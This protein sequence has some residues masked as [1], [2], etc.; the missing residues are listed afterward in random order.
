MKQPG[1]NLIEECRDAKHIVVTGHI[2]PD[3][4][5]IGSTVATTLFLR[6][7]LPEA[8]VRL[9]LEK[10]MPSFDGVEGIDIIDSTYSGNENET[11]IC[12]VLDTNAG[13]IGS[14]DRFFEK[15]K[16]TI[17]IDHHF[18]NAEGSAMLNYIDPEAS[19]ASEMVFRMI[20]KEAMDTQIAKFLYIGITHDTGVFR[21]NSTSRDTLLAAA[22]LITYDFDFSDLLEKTY[23]EK[24]Y[25]QVLNIAGIVEKAES[26]FGGKVIFGS[27]SYPEYVG[28]KLTPAD[29]DG[30]INEL[31]IIRG[32][33]CAIFMY[34]MNEVTYKV[35]MRSIGTVNVAN[36]CEQFGGGGH[37]R[38]AGFFKKSGL[39]ELKKEIL[40]A[41]AEQTG[42]KEE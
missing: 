30:A 14:A 35:S 23:Y 1:F 18:S 7:S 13:R 10:P 19:S 21:Y 4:D 6:K 17:N 11:D 26:Y 28:K 33:E 37:I 16:K 42:W 9:F 5:C 15:A 8:D 36:V 39:E 41:V 2:K 31:R 20:P 29:F 12:V 27:V 38:A 25:E 22:D 32:C 24:S 40:A 3:G 34:P